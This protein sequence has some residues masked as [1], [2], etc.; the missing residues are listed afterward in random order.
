MTTPL[1]ATWTRTAYT[2]D[3]TTIECYRKGTGPGVIVLHELPGLIPAVIAFG[4]EVVASG[5]TVV[6]P[7]LFGTPGRPPTAGHFAQALG[8]ICVRRE[9]TLVAMGRTTPLAGWL[10]ALARDLHAE[11]GGPGVGCIGMCFTGGFALAMMVDAPVVAPVVAQPANPGPIGRK[12]SA[13]LGLAPADLAAVKA[14]VDGGCP[15]MGLRYTEDPLVGTRFETLRRELGD[16]FFAV[17]FPGREH[18]VLAT[19]RRQD[20]VD[21]VLD[22]LR[23]RLMP[24]DQIGG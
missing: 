9:F 12:R 19:H 6:M 15:V 3:G 20:G 14:K 21:R 23:D 13:D 22:F 2:A 11:L 10:R 1:L 16:G 4:E 8:R 7:D 17:E 18:S 5:F 24:A